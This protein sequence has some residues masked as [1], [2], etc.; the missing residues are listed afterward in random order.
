MLNLRKSLILFFVLLYLPNGSIRSDSINENKIYNITSDSQSNSA[1][2]ILKATG[3]VIIEGENDFKV[4][5]DKLIY[6]KKFSK[7]L[8]KGNVTVRNYFSN[9]VFIKE[10]SGNE[11]IIFVDKGAFEFNKEEG[12]RVKTSIRF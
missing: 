5:A 3:N 12:Q 7:L 1:D 6:E 8:L 11:L 2:G 4:Y 9:E 10:A